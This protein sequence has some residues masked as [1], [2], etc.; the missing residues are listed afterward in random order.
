MREPAE[1]IAASLLELEIT[2]S[3]GTDADEALGGGGTKDSR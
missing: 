2:G 3:S 1:W